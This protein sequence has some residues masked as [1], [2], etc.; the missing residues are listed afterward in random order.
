M[1]PDTLYQQ[2]ITACLTR[3]DIASS[4]RHFHSNVKKIASNERI[5]AIPMV[6]PCFQEKN[7]TAL[8]QLA[9]VIRKRFSTVVVLGTGGSTLCPQTFSALSSSTSPTLHYADYI[10]PFEIERLGRTLDWKTTC[11]VA[12]SKS[13][14][15]LETLTQCLWAL[16]K[17]EHAGIKKQDIGKHFIVITDPIKS[18]LRTIASEI[19]AT[20]LDHP[21]DIGGRY[22]AFTAV[23]LLPALITG[24]DATRL[25]KG[26]RSVIDNPEAPLM[27]AA[28][29]ASF[30]E[31][32]IST[33]VFMPYVSRLKPLS[34]LFRQLWAES[35]G[36]NGK[37]G[38][39][40]IALGTLDQHSQ[41]QLYL[42]GPEDKW[43]TLLLLESPASAHQN[44]F[45][46]HAACSYL[47]NHTIS[48]VQQASQQA[49]IETLIS[50]KRPVR[51]ITL[52]QLHE[53]T[54]GALTMHLMLETFFT[55]Q[56]LRVDPFGQPAVEEGKQKA[57]L[58]LGTPL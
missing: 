10:D 32:H 25:C 17:L 53:E 5:P 4:Y 29:A 27:G 40:L 39:P 52:P 15:T 41:L 46:G 3:P 58:L 21:I 54:I 45:R 2:T 31:H 24:L 51:T 48:D 23:G 28:L 33:T 35:L 57:R 13:G 6:T 44:P 26:A 22:A 16:E 19:G 18:P 14:N 56:L 7:L 11:F 38:T 8:S 43:F 42:D 34:A 20:I 9:D 49:T 47:T 12:T 50:H 55:A 36:K 37:G 30:F 1:A